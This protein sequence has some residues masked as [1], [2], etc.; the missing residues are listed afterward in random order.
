V[1][2]R[3]LVVDD[4][5]EIRSFLSEVLDEEGYMV[6]TAESGEESIEKVKE[7]YFHGVILDVRMRGIDG[8]MAYRQIKQINPSIKAVI[9]TAFYSEKS[10]QSCIQP[11]VDT[12]LH[13]P[14]DIGQLLSIL[15][16][17]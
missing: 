12:C 6:D 11:G 1:K 9:V 4:E 10:I 13:K 8:I 14:F 15:K 5:S 17:F 2:K 7:N 16:N 3:I